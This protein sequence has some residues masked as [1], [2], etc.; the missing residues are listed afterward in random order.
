[1]A[2][3]VFGGQ[4][5]DTTGPLRDTWQWDG[6]MWSERCAEPAPC[7]FVSPPKGPG[8]AM[9]YDTKRSRAVL[10]GGDAMSNLWE[11]DGTI[12]ISRAIVTPG[13]LDGH[14]M[15]YDAKNAVVVAFGGQNNDGFHNN[16]WAWDG[17][18]WSLV[19]GQGSTCA[20]AGPSSRIYSALAYDSLNHWVFLFGG[21]DAASTLN[22]DAWRWDGE[23]KAWSALCTPTSPCTGGPPPARF[24]HALAYDSATNQVV[25]F[26]GAGTGGLL[27]DTWFF[28]GSS[29]TRPQHNAGPTPPARAR[30]AMAYDPVRN[31]VVLFGGSDSAARGDTWEWDDAKGWVEKLPTVHPA[32]RQGAQLAYD[33]ARGAILLFGGSDAQTFS[34]A[35][36]WDG[37]E[38]RQESPPP[39]VPPRTSHAMAYDEARRRIVV[40]G[41]FGDQSFHGD[42]WTHAHYAEAC[43]ASTDCDTGNCVDGVCCIFNCLTCE[44][45]N[46]APVG[47]CT[48][49]VDSEDPGACEGVH[50]CDH[51][52][53]CRLKN[54]QKCAS[55]VDCVSGFCVDGVCCGTV[56]NGPCEA[57]RASLKAS[58]VDGECG[59]AIAG[60]DPREDCAASDPCT[61]GP[62][63][64]CDGAWACRVYA[65]GTSGASSA[66][67][68]SGGNLGA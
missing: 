52:G 10:L 8:H 42:S 5:T 27:G 21:F 63:G 49:I 7:Y 38:W 34:D 39:P 55:D 48:A 18:Q 46:R 41:G 60:S 1:M 25:L 24:G 53:R 2:S 32:P 11:W 22:A 47:T 14:A 44:G 3:V 23:K 4:G 61:C 12:W 20:N 19:C 29:W 56:C 31:K 36:E 66:T 68:A 45:C 58:G 40:Q 15:T 9:A 35:W 59:N 67:G 62:D 50:A 33:R 13:F 54:G 30:H 37:V 57:C 51:V 65:K 6:S 43:T 26:G 28:D 64:T 17:T 16:T